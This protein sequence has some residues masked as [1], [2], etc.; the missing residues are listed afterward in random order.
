MITADSGSGRPSSSTTGTRPLGFF[1]YSHAGRSD[2]S[3]S[4]TSNST[5]FSARTIRTRAQYGQRGAS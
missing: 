3:I 5:S 4:T 2:R 1:S